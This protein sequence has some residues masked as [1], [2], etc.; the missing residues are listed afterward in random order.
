MTAVL[1][2]CNAQKI[3]NIVPVPPVIGSG[4]RADVVEVE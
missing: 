1:L 4:T 3:G 2:G